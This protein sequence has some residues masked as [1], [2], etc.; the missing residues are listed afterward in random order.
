MLDGV[1]RTSVETLCADVPLP[2]EQAIRAQRPE[3]MDGVNDWR[4]YVFDPAAA[5]IREQIVDVNHVWLKT[6]EGRQWIS[7]AT[8]S[9]PQ[10]RANRI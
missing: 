7:A 6:A 4:R 5:E 9:D 10:G 3:V 8:C 2:I 1:P